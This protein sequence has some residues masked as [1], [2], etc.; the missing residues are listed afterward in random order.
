[1]LPAALHTSVAL[2]IPATLT[3]SQ[4]FS[5]T[6][7]TP[8]SCSHL[9]W[10]QKSFLWTL[11]IT[12]LPLLHLFLQTYCSVLLSGPLWDQPVFTIPVVLVLEQGLSIFD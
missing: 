1:M 4:T 2:L 8:L 12:A 6:P 3:P 9:C 7:G 11:G 5:L 10:E